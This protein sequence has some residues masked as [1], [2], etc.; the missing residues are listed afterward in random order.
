MTE[1]KSR[2]FA[3]NEDARD[4]LKRRAK[5]RYMLDPERHR[6]KRYLRC[7]NAGKVQCPKQ[8][9]LLRHGIEPLE[10]GSFGVSVNR[11]EEKT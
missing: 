7:L 9:T 3:M 1:A 8:S 6:L 11:W 10:D 2:S 5:L 4:H